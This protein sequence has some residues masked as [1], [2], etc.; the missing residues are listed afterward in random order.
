VCNLGARVCILREHLSRACAMSAEH[1]HVRTPCIESVALSQKTG[2]RVRL[3][4]ENT[5]PSGSFKIR[6]IGRLVQS[7]VQNGAN[8]LISSSGGNAGMAA[9]YAARIVGIEA[10][11]FVP[12]TTSEKVRDR[13]RVEG[14]SVEVF[15]SVFDETDARARAEAAKDP[16]CVYVHP[17]DGEDIWDGHATL[18]QELFGDLRG[19]PPD[20][21]VVSVGGGGLLC[22]IVR[23][24]RSVG[25]ADKVRVVAMETEGANC[26]DEALNAGHLV[27]LPAITSIAKTLGSLTVAQ[28][29]FLYATESRGPEVTSLV[30]S[31]RC[32]TDACVDFADQHKM[33]VEPSCGAA[34]AA[35]NDAGM[36]QK[37]RRMPKTRLSWWWCVEESGYPRWI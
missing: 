32:A 3:K 14:A 18:V 15:G 4:L 10:C 16:K 23:G 28:E 34:L 22:G 26:L 24:L 20:F 13:L 1:L 27:T 21:L 8:R 9:A 29:A 35:V 25:W 30:V 5:Q 36:F 12:T 37:W 33:L 31:D 2:C 19:I 7:A 11:I 6:G 17:F